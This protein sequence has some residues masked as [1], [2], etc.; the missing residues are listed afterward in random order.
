MEYK[1]PLI[2]TD[3]QEDIELAAK[4]ATAYDASPEYKVSGIV[5]RGAGSLAALHYLNTTLAPVVL[6]YMSF[7]QK[8][9][10]LMCMSL[11]EKVTNATAI[12]ERSRERLI[13]WIS[14]SENKNNIRRSTR[15]ETGSLITIISI[16]IWA[17]FIKKSE[18]TINTTTA[19]IDISTTGTTMITA[20]TT[21]TTMLTMLTNSYTT[22][23]NVSKLNKWKQ[24][25]ITVAGGNGYGEELNQLQGPIGI[26]IDKN[27]NIFIADTR[28]HRIVEWKYNAKEGQIIVGGNGEGNPMDQLDRPIDVI[29]DQHNHSIII[30]DYKNR[31]LIQWLNQNKQILINNIDCY[32]LAIDKHEFLYVSDDAKNAVRR[33]KMGDYNNE[34][35]V[36]VGGN[37]KGNQLNQLNDPTFIFVDED[38]S[39]YVSDWEN[40]R[41]MKWRKDA[42]EGIIVAGGNGQGRNLN[43]LSYPAGVIV[44]DL[45]QIYV[46]DAGNHRIMRW[47]EGKEQ[48]EVVVGGNGEG[49][50]SNQ[51]HSPRRLSFDGEGNLYVVDRGNHRIQ[52]FEILF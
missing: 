29:V 18:T 21:K 7:R 15:Q 19:K 1:K 10:C 26:F 34:G 45:G 44:D 25:A 41:V 28:N 17:I 31:R 36:V 51:L 12:L 52:K 16:T 2:D 37:G 33:W 40:H 48:G 14:E 38:Q 39:V 49:I 22:T 46:A 20:S 13:L 4:R 3:E 43:Q 8:T 42:K 9:R 11:L 27:K 35:I 5:F 24:N 50:Q 32:G 6:L 47:C 30:T 23:K